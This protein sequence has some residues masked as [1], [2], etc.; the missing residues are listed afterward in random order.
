[1]N[2]NFFSKDDPA[3]NG[4]HYHITKKQYSEEIHNIYNVDKSKPFNTKDNIFLI[5]QHFN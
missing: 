4:R 5:E 2:E 1:M 3:I